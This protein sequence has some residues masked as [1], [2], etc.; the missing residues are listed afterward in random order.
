VSG[1]LTPETVALIRVSASLAA[2]EAEALNESLRE[3]AAVADGLRVEEVLLQSYLFLGYPIALNGLA[4]WR[5][6]SGAAPPSPA[7]E[8]WDEWAERGRAVCQTVYRNQYD[9]L[10]SNVR[11]LHPDL[12]RWMVVEGYGKVL[13][14]PRL[15]LRVRELCIAAQL[16]V[17]GTPTQLYSHLRGAVNAGAELA[18]VEEALEVTSAYLADELRE[19]ASRTWEAVLSRKAGASP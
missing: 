9:G 4:R 19:L 15:P 11:A 2:R 6:I 1:L 13:G 18:E 3:A 5:E 17:L 16:A 12:E 10:R 14:R 8:D 7:N